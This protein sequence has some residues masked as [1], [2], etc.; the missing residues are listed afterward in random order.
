MKLI[1]TIVLLNLINISLIIS[2]NSIP[3]DK[4]SQYYKEAKAISDRDSSKLWGIPIYVPT[5]FINPQTL[6]LVSNEMDNE[7]LFQKDEEIYRGKF[8]ANKIVANSTTLFG[9]KEFTMVIYPLPDEEYTRNVLIIHEMFHYRQPELGLSLPEGVGYNNS[10]AD[11][12]QARI[13]FKLEWN[14]LEKAIEGNDT[15]LCR[16][17]INDALI[18]RAYRRSLYENSAV[19]ENLFELHEGLPEYTAHTLCAPSEDAL[20]QQV[21]LSKERISNNPSYVRSFAYFSGLIYGYL[22]D[23]TNM[24]WRKSIKYNGDL[25]KL[26]QTAY[27]TELPDDINN[28]QEKIRK[29]Y[30]YEAIHKFEIKRKEEKDQLLSLYMEIFTQRPILILPL[31]QPNIGFNPSNVLSLGEQ[32]TVYP[33]DFRVIDKWGKLTVTKGACLLANNWRQVTVPAGNMQVED[34][35]I[36]T[37][38]WLL[39][40]NDE[41]IVK[42]AGT[43]YILERK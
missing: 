27:Q 5:L 19:N 2:Q 35:L 4:A 18:F 12:I 14:A 16:K 3:G 23:K 39:E 17:Y 22:L 15:A 1:A 13:Y 8:P 29:E 37:P 41:Y 33:D 24:E 36:K 11:D 42:K 25:G 40:L 34:N 31:S 7:G 38:S 26:L 10:H 32:G 43:N 9:G 6:E 20:K 30:D 21:L 28:T